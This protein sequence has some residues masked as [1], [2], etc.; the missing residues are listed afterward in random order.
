M[1]FAL[2][3]SIF[4]GALG[5]V[6]DGGRLFYEKRQAQS[7]ADSG[8]I[9][10][11]QELRR[12]NKDY[13][14]QVRPAVVNDTA[15]HG[16]ADTNSTITVDYPPAQ[17]PHA[18]DPLFVEVFVRKQVPTTFMRILGPKYSYVTA[19]A[20]SGL[21]PSPDPC[22]LILD[23]EVSGAYTQNGSPNVS[24]DCGF[25]VN[26]R[27]G[28]ALLEK[29]S[30]CL[31]ASWVGVTGGYGGNCISPSPTTGVSPMIDPF[32]ALAPPDASAMS[33]GGFS[34]VA[35][36][37]VY[38]PGYYSSKIQIPNGNV[39]FLPGTYV[40]ERGMKVTGGDLFG[41]G[42]FFYNVN[43][44]GNDHIDI[45]G[46]SRVR[47]SALQ[48]GAYKGMLFFANRDS[49]DKSPGNLLGRG[50]LDSY[51]SGA[52]YFPSQHLDW[53]GNPDSDMYWAMVV[54]NTLN[55]SGASGITI[56]VNKPPKNLSPPAYAAVLWE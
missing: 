38:R 15:L 7:A 41:E 35:G 52:L 50:T 46:N 19:R 14:T 48:F 43:T 36:V 47:L 17:G 10:G 37:R 12:G 40:L 56:R 26:S 4:V 29:G 27:S 22:V 1:L 23:P 9:A 24:T 54:A 53:A 6:L 28:S 8:A 55:V 44:N 3:F 34:V 33:A 21:R 16:Y 30:G 49:P 11:A 25:M 13:A 51:Y 42:V 45:G 31:E 20:T 2:L 5:L 18:G 32:S 39:V